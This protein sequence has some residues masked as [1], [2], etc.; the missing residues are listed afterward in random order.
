MSNNKRYN[1]LLFLTTLSVYMG[2]VL[3]GSPPQVLAETSAPHVKFELNKTKFSA[4]AAF[5]A[6]ALEKAPHF[7]ELFNDSQQPVNCYTG[8]QKYTFPNTAMDAEN[9]QNFVVARL[10]RGSLDTLLTVNQ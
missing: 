6:S 1:Q 7:S 10:P 9:D 2:L 8:A 3:V 4:R 5:D